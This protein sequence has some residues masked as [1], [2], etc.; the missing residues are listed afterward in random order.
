[1]PEEVDRFINQ[2][3]HRDRIINDDHRGGPQ[4]TLKRTDIGIVH[5]RI[6]DFVIIDD[7]QGGGGAGRH[8]R[9]DG[10]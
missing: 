4:L 2:P 10:A 5:W 8:D 7:D 3:I 6:Q 1:M 9:F